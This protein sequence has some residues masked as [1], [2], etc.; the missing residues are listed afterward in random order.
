ML[1]HTLVS[2]I[3]QGRAFSL[4]TVAL[5]GAAT[6]AAFTGKSWE[7]NMQGVLEEGIWVR[8]KARS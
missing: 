2:N 1:N 6:A 8:K 4:V 7:E 3:A 5:P